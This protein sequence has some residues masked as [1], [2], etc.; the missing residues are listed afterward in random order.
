MAFTSADLASIDAAIASGEMSVEINGKR[1]QYR[2]VGELT[3]ARR[4]IMAELAAAT[5]GAGTNGVR[6]G[7]YHPVF[8]TSRR[9]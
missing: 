2:S 9:G 3:D 8:V 6:R 5:T 7:T 4:L 1:V